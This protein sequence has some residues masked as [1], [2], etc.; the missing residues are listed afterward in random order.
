MDDTSFLNSIASLSPAS[1]SEEKIT[2]LGRI[3]VQSISPMIRDTIA[4]KFRE[5]KNPLCLP[6]LI[7]GI[8]RN[9]N[10]R[11]V[12]QLISA[13]EVFDCR[14]YL[15]VFVDVVILKSD[16]SI[17]DAAFVIG[18]SIHF[19]NTEVDRVFAIQKLELFLGTVAGYYPCKREIRGGDT[20]DKIPDRLK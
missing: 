8:K 1:L 6:Y 10:S 14:D 16:S 5:S 11:H 3:L 20:K 4:A 2:E 17:L 7:D 12:G 18:E 13:C 9:L 15:Q 19:Y